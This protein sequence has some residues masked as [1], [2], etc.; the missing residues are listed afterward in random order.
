MPRRVRKTFQRRPHGVELLRGLRPSR[1]EAMAAEGLSEAARQYYILAPE[2]A[3]PEP[4]FVLKH[5][6][7]FGLFNH[8][9]D[10]DTGARHE[11]GLFHQGT[12]FLSQYLLTLAGGRPLLLS[13][14]CR[15]DN[16]LVAAD[17]TNPDIYLDGRVVL[18][19]GSLH[20]YRSKL[21]WQAVCYENLHIR[22]FTREPVEIA[23]TLAF[24][25]DY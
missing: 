19:R 20:I 10:I 6:E 22:N 1:R 9:G 4:T 11:E 21:L 8:F 7:T 15:R 16:L 12:R 18:P 14:A 5:D 24:A 25:A 17:L 3:V 2:V 13:A 23:L